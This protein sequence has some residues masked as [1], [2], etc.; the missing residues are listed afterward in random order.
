MKTVAWLEEVGENDGE[1][2]GGK[3]ASLGEMKS[4]F[5]V[6]EGFIVTTEAYRKFLEES[7]IKEELLELSKKEKAKESRDLILE[8]QTPEEIKETIKES[9]RDLGNGRVAVRSS[10]TAEDLPDASFAGQQ[11]TFL[12]VMGEDEV[13][14]KIKEC[15]SS[16]FTD[17][18]VSYREEK[19]FDHSDVEIAVVVQ[20]M[21]DSE[22]SGVMFT[23]DPSTGE[24]NTTIEAS[25]GLGESVVG[26]GVTPDN[27]VIDRE[28]DK[29]ISKQIGSKKKMLV[30][31]ESNGKGVIEK[32]VPE[33]KRKEQV[34]SDEEI[35]KLVE[36]G[37]R[38]EEHYG[39]PQDVEWAIH[40]GE[41]YIVQSRPITTIKNKK[42]GKDGEKEKTTQK[43]NSFILKGLGASPGKQLGKVKIVKNL[44]ELDKV[45]K[46]DVLV[47]EQTTPDMVPA[48]KKAVAIITDEGGLTSHAA[49]VSRELGKVAVVGTEDATKKLKDGD[50]VSVDGD[51]GRVKKT[52]KEERIEEK[53]E[54]SEKPDKDIKP[55]EMTEKP[56]ITTGTEI[57]V[58]VS[59]PEAA[60]RGAAT[61]A[62]GVG[63]LRLEHM[64]LELGKTPKRFV[65]EKSRKEY[66]NALSD[67]IRK[68]AEAFYPKPVRVRTL[69][70][71]TD[72]FR[73][74]KGGEEEPV[75]DNP[76]LGYRGIRRS[77]R[78]PGLFKLQLKAFKELEE[79]GYDN[80]E[81]MLPLVRD[82]EETKRGKEIMDEVGLDVKWGVM[83]ETPASAL[84]I[85]DIIDAGV[86]FVSFGTNDLTQYTLAV[87]RNNE[88]VANLYD[89]LHPGVKRLIEIVT[90]KCREEDVRTGICGEAG[91]RPEM[92]EFL[93]KQGVD[94]ISANIDAVVDI[95]ETVE[96]K[97]RRLLL[98]G[99]R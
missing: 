29:I 77:L 11:E 26:G 81:V 19:G 41:I 1:I 5:P 85:D 73:N 44:D 78:E 64:I 74:L 90:E 8:A 15:W 69:D 43:E 39:I 63:L 98:D 2:V 61:G 87:D 45:E 28:K 27:Y 30:R 53:E 20:K 21:V 58:N 86:E 25:W 12:E 76:M 51:K 70:A 14:Q 75:E 24:E 38:L 48:M 72:E 46:G 66:I 49:I 40:N 55:K 35:Q 83:I 7:G 96:R 17:R 99:V 18:A 97:E 57:R 80:L 93:V 13:I 65:E 33:E 37:E 59:L 88:R 16:L 10:A 34:L 31:N 56:R 82:G 71:P 67:G 54:T 4:E 50:Y 32:E 91:S 62:D 94:S 9:Y 92:A 22:K 47:T 42:E 95:R 84:V 68:V 6:P 52:K 89:E 36:I 23:C 60:E 79:E 3:G